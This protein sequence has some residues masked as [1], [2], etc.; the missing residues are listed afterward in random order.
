[1]EKK[2]KKAEKSKLFICGTDIESDS[3]NAAYTVHTKDGKLYWHTFKKWKMQLWIFWQKIK[4]TKI[5]KDE[6]IA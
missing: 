3:S 2:L 5:Y 1:M 6:T 4:G